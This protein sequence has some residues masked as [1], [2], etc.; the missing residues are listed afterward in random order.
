MD[1][2]H[3][4]FEKAETVLL[5]CIVQTNHSLPQ[6]AR[7][8]AR[9]RTDTLALVSKSGELSNQTAFRTLNTHSER[10]KIR[11]YR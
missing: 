2:M 8:L 11:I 10:S 9:A 3:V 5:F 6:A 7:P 1:K 4:W